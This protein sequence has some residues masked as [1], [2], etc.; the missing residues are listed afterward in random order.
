MGIFVGIAKARSIIAGP[1]LITLGLRMGLQ[2]HHFTADTIGLPM[3]PV[4]IE[5]RVNFATRRLMTRRQ[6]VAGLSCITFRCLMNLLGLF[7][8]PTG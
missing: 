5:S 2:R 7:G 8:H 1:I 6:G 3:S 4:I